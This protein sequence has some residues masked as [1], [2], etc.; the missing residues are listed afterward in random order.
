MLC[1]VLINS[2]LWNFLMSLDN[3]YFDQRN[4]KHAQISKLNPFFLRMNRQIP[5]KTNDEGNDYAI[6][7]A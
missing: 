1:F 7:I 6:S 5:H 2:V 3:V 4:Q